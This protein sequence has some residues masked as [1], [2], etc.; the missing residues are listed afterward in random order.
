MTRIRLTP[1]RLPEDR[2]TLRIVGARP[3]TS[4]AGYP[5]LRLALVVEGGPHTGHPLACFYSLLPQ[6][7]W[8]LRRL[9]RATRTPPGEDALD[10]LDLLNVRLIATIRSRA[11]AFGP[12]TYELDDESPADA[13]W[14]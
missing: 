11:S 12:P 6:A 9:L 1:E 14:R 8:R 13:P 3:A 2:Y 10:T 7:R 5:T 4:R